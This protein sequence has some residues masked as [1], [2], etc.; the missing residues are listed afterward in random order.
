MK[1]KILNMLFIVI[2]MGSF[3]A[4][5]IIN[6]NASNKV[7]IKLDY[8]DNVF[9]VRSGNNLEY[10]SGKYLYYSLDG[11]VAYCI[12]PGI[13][14]TDWDY[15]FSTDLTTSPHSKEVTAK[16][17]LVGYYGYEY[18]GHQTQKYRMATQAIIWEL[19]NGQ[20]VE[21]Y[22]KINGGGNKI[23]ITPERNEIMRLVNSHY[24]KPSLNAKN[25]KVKL[26]EQLVID[27]EKNVL[28]NYE[29]LSN[30]DLDV[31]ISGNSLSINPKNFGTFKVTLKKKT[32]DD[33][34]TLIY[35]GEN[36]TSQKLLRCRISDP[37]YATFNIEV[38]GGTISIEKVDSETGLSNGQGDSTLSGA[39]Y[40][41]YDENNTLLTKL[42]TDT[43]GKATS[44]YLNKLG[45]F[46]LKEIS[47]SKGYLLDETVYNFEIKEDNLNVKLKVKENVIKHN[48]KIY[49]VLSNNAIGIIDGEPNITFEVYLKSTGKLYKTITTD[50]YGYA[51]IDLPYGTY[52]F[53]QKNTTKDY[54]KVDDF[55]F[56]VNSVG[57]SKKTLYDRA[58]EAKLKVVKI[59]EETG[60]VIKMSGIKF[61]IK[62]LKT[63]EYLCPDLYESRSLNACTYAT[64]ENGVMITPFELVGD[65]SLEEVDQTIDGYLWNDK[66]INFHIG[67]GSNFEND[68][69]LGKLFVVKFPNKSVKGK[70]EINKKGEQVSINNGNYNYEEIKLENV[71]FG[72]Y[73]ENNNLIKEV[74]TDKNG[75]AEIPN[76]ELGKYFLKELSS[77]NNN[78]VDENVYEFELK[79]KD[80]YTPVIVKTFDLKNNYS[81]GK[82][83]FSKID[84]STSEPLPDTKIEIYTT[85]NELVY[86]GRTDKNGKIVINNLFVGKYYILEKEAPEGYV[87]NNEKMYFEL[88]ENGEVVKATM[89]NEK[90]H[91][92]LEFTK[93]DFSTSE[94]LPNTLIEIY[95]AK[96]DEL[97]FAGRTDEL[98]KIIIE[99]LEY[100]KYYILEKEAP[101]SYV[102]N[103]EKMYFEIKKDGEIVKST[104]LNKK[105]TSTLKIHKLDENNKSLQ[106]VNIGI[107]NFDGT[108]INSLLTD[109]NGDIELV[110]EFGNYYFQ[111]IASIEGYQ[112][113]NEKV[114]FEITKDGEYIQKEL[115]NLLVPLTFKNDYS[116]IGVVLLLGIGVIGVIYG[117]FKYKKEN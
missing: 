31:K 27:D 21:F 41:V 81:K 33:L 72:L 85:N 99:R 39:V 24:E 112:L 22:T 95:R 114:Y 102:L 51:D 3:F 7:K 44:G 52:I 32:Y 36:N 110:L 78:V 11:D 46:T 73:D 107:Y 103:T 14:I 8:Q 71:K 83:E 10:H 88:K 29:L 86:V 77:S 34:T 35:T 48:L 89:T 100:G 93:L 60:E 97:I 50:K 64:D 111:E 20:N 9:Y 37:V 2:A 45:N 57:N 30:N 68:E 101:I 17:Q 91:G 61:K 98:G 47:S 108:L 62:S 28:E 92:K 1:N 18:P 49:K 59:D 26:G 54:E 53:K 6:V 38:Y 66:K 116:S 25:Y 67:E 5:S 75:Y 109:E 96:N 65:F 106:G 23:D 63:N 19:A 4:L 94:P 12:E 43:N 70:V 42:T 58:M 113:S 90:I 105:I 76:L 74:I 16:M 79:Y 13:Q 104:M 115:I 56:V 40:G 82:L 15:L 117:T 55:E 80:Q 84:F 87:L 69:N